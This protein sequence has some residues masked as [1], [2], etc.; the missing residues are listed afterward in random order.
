MEHHLTRSFA[1][2]AFLC[3]TI[4]C[5]FQACTAPAPNGSNTIV[6]PAG[7]ELKGS[8]VRNIP[9][10]GDIPTQKFAQVIPQIAE[11]RMDRA[12]VAIKVGEGFRISDLRV[13][14]YDSSGKLLGRLKQTDRGA[15]PRDVLSM[16]SADIVQGIKPGIGYLELSAPAWS[17]FGGDR[18]KPTLRLEVSVSN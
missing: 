17:Q 4:C 3:S 18:P 9:E 6:V 1:L 7:D 13:L 15:Q 5:L 10:P 8:N 16:T 11:L 12:S 2:R 14:A